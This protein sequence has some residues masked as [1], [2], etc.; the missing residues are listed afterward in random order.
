MEAKLRRRHLGIKRNDTIKDK[1]KCP[2]CHNNKVWLKGRMVECTKC[3]LAFEPDRSIRLKPDIEIPALEWL[4][5][6][7]WK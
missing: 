3:K 6:K 2:R 1:Y 7:F 5:K 4:K